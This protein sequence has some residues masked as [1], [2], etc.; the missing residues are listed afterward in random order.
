MSHRRQGR[1]HTAAA[2]QWVCSASIT[3]GGVLCYGQGPRLYTLKVLGTPAFGSSLWTTA[4]DSDSRWIA[5]SVIA[6]ALGKAKPKLTVLFIQL[7]LGFC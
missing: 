7:L 5:V 1:P 3:V 2:E 4:Q 6:E